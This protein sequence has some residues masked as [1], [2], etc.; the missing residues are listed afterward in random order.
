METDLKKLK[1][2][3][4]L[5]NCHCSISIAPESLGN[6]LTLLKVSLGNILQTWKVVYFFLLFILNFSV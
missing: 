4:V 6:L 3:K 5:V 1:R 2:K